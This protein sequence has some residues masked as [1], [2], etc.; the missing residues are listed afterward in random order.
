MV[1][2][3]CPLDPH[4]FV[5]EQPF[6]VVGCQPPV[7]EAGPADQHAPQSADLGPHPDPL[8]SHRSNATAASAVRRHRTLTRGQEGRAERA[9]LLATI[10]P[11]AITCARPS[12]SSFSFASYSLFAWTTKIVLIGS[13]MILASGLSALQLPTVEPVPQ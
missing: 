2:A 13:C 7:R 9:G 5:I 6:G 3:L 4:D 1:I 11:S 8:P 10:E 12:W